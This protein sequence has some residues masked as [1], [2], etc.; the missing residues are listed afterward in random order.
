MVMVLT[1]PCTILCHVEAL[2]W[3]KA[4]DG[5]SKDAKDGVGFEVRRGKKG[6]VLQY[7]AIDRVSGYPS[8]PILTVCPRYMM[9]VK[10]NVAQCCMNKG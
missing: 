4:S 3:S 7:S 9:Y 1:T 6:V 8:G 2:H 10:S 5:P